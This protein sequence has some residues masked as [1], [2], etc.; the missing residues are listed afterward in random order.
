VFLASLERVRDGVLK[1]ARILSDPGMSTTSSNRPS[2]GKQTRRA[3]TTFV[4]K[5]RSIGWGGVSPARVRP[6]TSVSLPR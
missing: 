1:Q 6:R 4:S 3:L 2:G 5:V